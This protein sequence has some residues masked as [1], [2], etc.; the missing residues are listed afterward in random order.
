MEVDHF[1][2]KVDHFLMSS[3]TWADVDEVVEDFEADSFEAISLIV[4][5]FVELD[6]D[7]RIDLSDVILLVLET[8]LGAFLWAFVFSDIGSFFLES[9][10][11]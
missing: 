3:T 9:T 11:E 6:F 4:S 7:N 8:V 1:F 2:S 5:L 10:S